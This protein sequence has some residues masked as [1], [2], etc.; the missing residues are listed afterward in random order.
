M[1]KVSAITG[2]LLL[3]AALLTAQT[4][5]PSE[6]TSGEPKS[7]NQEAATQNPAAQDSAAEEA[8]IRAEL[9]A[10]VADWNRSDL[11][12]YM[13]GYWHSPELTFFA[14][15]KESNGWEAAYQ[16]YRAAYSGKDKTMGKLNFSN[17]RVEVLGPE[18][19]FVRGGWQL[20]M[21]DGS[22]RSGLFTVV[23]K[24]FSNGWRIIH[25]HSS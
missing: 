15:N 13:Q 12:G 11:K 23:L 21:K 6:I 3:F 24:K 25:D 10:Q 4:T 9:D 22:K 14:G 19:A 5:A 20:T 1:A 8:A 2:V 18:A 16:R 17:L 7:P